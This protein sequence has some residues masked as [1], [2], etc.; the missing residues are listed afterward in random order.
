MKRDSWQGRRPPSV[1]GTPPSI[2]WRI[3]LFFL[4]LTA[5]SLVV[6]TAEAYPWMIRHKYAACGMCHVD[7]SGG[8]L[9]TGFGRDQGDLMMDTQYQVTSEDQPKEPSSTSGFLWGALRLPEWLFLGGDF[10]G[11][12]LVVK[13]KGTPTDVRWVPMQV[14][15]RAALELD[16]F[17]A[18][19]SLG[20]A[21]QGALPAAMTHRDADNLMSREHWLGVALDDDA[22]WLRAGRMNLP[23]GIRNI[24]HT[25]WV[26]SSTRTDINASQQYGAAVV[27]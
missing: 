16:I 21:H 23:F 6:T 5:A 19:G 25:L 8:G 26:R 2:G 7:P 4:V 10:R 13:P 27:V 12:L 9:L 14:D 22:V 24:E 18:G 1:R 17:R 15:L 3:G 20:Y 11:M